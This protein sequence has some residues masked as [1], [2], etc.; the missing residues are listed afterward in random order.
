MGTGQTQKRPPVKMAAFV[1]HE[2]GDLLL[3]EDILDV[4]KGVL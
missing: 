3:I 4:L 1:S 2:G